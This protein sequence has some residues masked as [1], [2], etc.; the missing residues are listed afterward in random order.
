MEYC[1]INDQSLSKLS[2][3]AVQDCKS[4]LIAVIH[5]ISCLNS[6]QNSSVLSLVMFSHVSHLGALHLFTH[7]LY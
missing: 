7:T 5:Q 3:S 6:T 1:D 2:L 4:N